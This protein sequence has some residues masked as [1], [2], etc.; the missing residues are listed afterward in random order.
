MQKRLL[1]IG[2]LFFIP[3]PNSFSGNLKSFGSSITE[4]KQIF[5]RK[6]AKF[7]YIS[8]H[9][10]AQMKLDKQHFYK[11]ISSN[12]I[13]L[14]NNELTKINAAKQPELNPFK[15]ALL[16]KRA[17]LEKKAAEK[18]N[19]FKEGRLLLE[20]A[21]NKNNKNVELRF[22]RLMIQENAPKILGYHSNIKEDVNFIQENINQ[23]PTI[24]QT[25]IFDY[26]KS[27]NE[28]NFNE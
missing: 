27:S 15:G 5:F 14:I 12:D 4:T 24:L 1:I 13:E 28:L 11:I 16:M 21:I 20:T 6:P 19:L 2:F 23:L 18:L 9:L 7:Q 25:I 3:N 22:L 26:A 8:T 10:A 17:G